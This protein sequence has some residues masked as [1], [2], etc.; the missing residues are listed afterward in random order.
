[1]SG[2]KGLFKA[3]FD[4][5]STFSGTCPKCRTSVDWPPCPNCGANCWGSFT[6]SHVRSE[7]S[8]TCKNCKKRYESFTCSCGCTVNASHFFRD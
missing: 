6:S 3:F 5:G 1:M 2:F 8:L 4:I 7:T